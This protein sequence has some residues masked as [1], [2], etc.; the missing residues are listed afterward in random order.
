[1]MAPLRL[2]CSTSLLLSAIALPVAAEQGR[3]DHDTPAT[4]RQSESGSPQQ[5][6]SQACRTDDDGWVLCRDRNGQWQRHESRQRSRGYSEPDSIDD[7][8]GRLL[9]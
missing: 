5:Y 8:I 9:R 4:Q 2:V 1:M 3:G 6:N 7:W